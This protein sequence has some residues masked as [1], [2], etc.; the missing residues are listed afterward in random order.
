MKRVLTCVAIGLLVLGASAAIADKLSDFKEAVNKDGC[1]SIP[2]SDLRGNCTSEQSYVH[3]WCDGNR[4]PV[5]C[6]SENITRELKANLERERKKL[7]TLKDKKRSLEDARGRATED[8]DKERLSMPRSS[9]NATPKGTRTYRS[10]DVCE[11]LVALAI[12]RK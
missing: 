1:E 7:D 4:G 10:M 2:Y 9:F 5:T 8:A 11:S 12:K 3:D 6:D